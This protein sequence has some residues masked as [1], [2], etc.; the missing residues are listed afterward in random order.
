MALSAGTKLNSH[1]HGKKINSYSV[2]K[3][4]NGRLQRK[5]TLEY[6]WPRKKSKPNFLPEVARGR[7]RSL[8]VL[9]QLLYSNGNMPSHPILNC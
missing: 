1:S 8:M 9:P 2:W 6:Q 7:P 3:K 5:T 4:L